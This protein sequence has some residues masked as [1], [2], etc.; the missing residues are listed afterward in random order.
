MEVYKEK[1]IE[2]TPRG[3]KSSN[4]IHDVDVIVLATGFQTSGGFFKG[5][6][7]LGRNGV[8]A[9]QHWD[10]IGGVGAYNTTA[11]HDFPNLFILL[12]PNSATGHTSAIVA[13]EK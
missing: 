9:E 2:I 7:V 1:A 4:G 10:G 8:S 3:I 12:G 5:M 6:E 11:M 13:I